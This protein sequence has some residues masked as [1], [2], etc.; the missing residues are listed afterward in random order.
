MAALVPAPLTSPPKPAL[1]AAPP[2]AAT[3]FGF[4]NSVLGEPFTEWRASLPSRKTAPCAN[5]PAGQ[6]FV[7]CHGADVDLGGGYA[8]RELAY[9]FVGG[10]L[11]SI[12]F[13]T[14]VDGFDFTTAVLKKRFGE[15][16]LVVRD[17][18]GRFNF[19]HVSMI[20]RNGRSTVLLSDPL[21]DYTHL[22]VRFI[23]GPLSTQLSKVKLRL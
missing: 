11:A 17:K 3:R 16:S 2:L 7:L 8:A 5:D 12:S 22:S 4:A 19:P 20:W 6:A 13:K 21:P 18:T 23:Y 15:P 14:S 10:R 9:V 1:A